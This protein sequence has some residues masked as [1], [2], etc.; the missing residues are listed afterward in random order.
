MNKV[1]ITIQENGKERAVRF[2]LPERWEEV[3]GEQALKLLPAMGGD[4]RSAAIVRVLGVLMGGQ[5]GLLRQM[6]PGQV[7]SLGGLVSW[8]W[9]K[10]LDV[11]CVK[12]FKIRY[13]GRR[14][15]YLLPS[16]KLE[17][18]TCLEWLL[19]D[20]A[21]CDFRA[22]GKPEDL[23][24]LMGAICREKDSNKRAGAA[25]DDMRVP[26]LS[27]MEMEERAKV[28]GKAEADVLAFVL[29]FFSGCKEW[30]FETYKPW[31]FEE[32]EELEEGEEP[33]E[34]PKTILDKLGW[35][36]MF[37]RVAQDGLFG[38]LEEVLTRAKF[39][40]VCLYLITKKA[41]YD[42]QLRQQREQ[43]GRKNSEE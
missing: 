13:K 8:L 7:V 12:S 18:I 35:Y 41:E 17:N 26:L 37:Q 31:L 15:D 11:N 4:D 16:A 39:K 20:E 5:A 2:D 34:R 10:R 29:A 42:E 19:A 22:S 36:G 28:M 33:E 25:R 30:V 40:D 23:Y 27:R 38:T 3:T 43:R 32:P 9:V 6:E 24:R 1:K 21:F 14:N